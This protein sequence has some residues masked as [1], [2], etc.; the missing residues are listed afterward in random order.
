MAVARHHKHALV[1]VL[2]TYLVMSFVPQLGLMNVL[3][4]GKGGKPKAG[5]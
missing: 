5:G 3:G 1:A 2:A 4:K